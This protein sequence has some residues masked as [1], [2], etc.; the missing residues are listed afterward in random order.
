MIT[1]EQINQHWDV[2]AD[3]YDEHVCGELASDRAK[4][5]VS[6][7][8]Q[9][10]PQ[11]RPLHVLDAGCGPG[12]FPVL[13]S[14]AGHLVTGIDGS[15]GMLERAR[16]NAA[17]QGVGPELV[18]G[19]FGNLPFPD[20]TFDLIVNRN[21]THII[22]EH[23]KVYGEWNRV[24]KPGGTLLIFDANWHLPYHPGPVRED[25]IRRE[26]ACLERYGKGFTHDGSYEYIDSD[27][28]FENYRVFGTC[29]RPDFDIGVLSQLPFR[30]ITFERDVTEKLWSDKEKLMYGAT[31]LYLV[32]AVKE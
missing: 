18:Q 2:R 29:S 28:D 11:T 22:R 27:L 5:W 10:A 4:E 9:N 3:M 21:V 6:L 23:L 12:F 26:R 16:K 25:A 30:E 17:E 24:L 13:L 15:L 19:D 8:E 14:K 1:Q 32:R 20:D 31:P 7:I